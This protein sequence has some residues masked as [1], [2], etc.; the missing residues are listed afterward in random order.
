MASGLLVFWTSEVSRSYSHCVSCWRPEAAR[1]A[2]RQSNV[3]A[4]ARYLRDALN[5]M[6][7][8]VQ[9][10]ILDHEYSRYR[11]FA[12]ADAHFHAAIA[13]ASGNRLLAGT[14]AGLNAHVHSY[15]LF[16]RTEIYA[17][18][19]AEHGAILDAL[20]DRDPG[21]AGSAMRSH[22]EQSRDRLLG[23]VRGAAVASHGPGP[24]GR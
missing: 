6:A 13:S 21:E 23:G 24:A 2:A 8:S 7:Q 10:P 12:E 17:V 20:A 18:T 11:G 9:A 14:L 5:E 3:T 4:V 1:E 22:L 16:F 19:L 15:R